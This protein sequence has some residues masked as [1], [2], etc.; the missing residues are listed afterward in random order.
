MVWR[1][2]MKKGNIAFLWFI[3][4]IMMM[5]IVVLFLLYKGA[6]KA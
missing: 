6:L 4:G 1:E 5:A 3:A 2:K